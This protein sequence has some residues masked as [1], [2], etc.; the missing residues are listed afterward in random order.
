MAIIILGQLRDRRAAPTLETFAS[1]AEL[2][3]VARQALAKLS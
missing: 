1:D 2:G 3:A